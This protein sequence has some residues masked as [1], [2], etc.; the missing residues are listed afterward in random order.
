MCFDWLMVRSLERTEILGR[1]GSG[2]GG[3][4][5]GICKRVRVPFGFRMMW[6]DL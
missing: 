3:L 2:E 6:S 5:G 1:L 4:C